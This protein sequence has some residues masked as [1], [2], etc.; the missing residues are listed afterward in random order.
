MDWMK[1]V[2]KDYKKYM[3]GKEKKP[4]VRR[5]L[6]IAALCAVMAGTV[7]LVVLLYPSFRDGTISG[8]EPNDIVESIQEAVTESFQNSRQGE[9][10]FLENLSAQNQ[11]SQSALVLHCYDKDNIAFRTGGGVLAFTDRTILTSYS[12]ATSSRRME[13]YTA[14]EPI[15][16]DRIIAWDKALNIAILGTAEPVQQEPLLIGNSD[17]THKGDE[18][19]VPTAGQ[20]TFLRLSVQE[21]VSDGTFFTLSGTLPRIYGASAVLD[22]Q[23][24]LVALAVEPG[25]T[26]IISTAIPLE[27]IQQQYDERGPGK[28]LEDH[29]MEQHDGVED[30]YLRS[31]PVNLTNLLDDPDLFNSDEN[32]LVRFEADIIPV[33]NHRN[34]GYYYYKTVKPEGRES[35]IE[36]YDQL[37][38]IQCVVTEYPITKNPRGCRAMICG[39]FHYTPAPERSKSLIKTDSILSFIASLTSGLS[40][41][42][43]NYVD[44]LK[45]VIN[46]GEIK[47]VSASLNVKYYEVLDD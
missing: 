43:K 14:E 34:D 26:E 36:F 21:V 1:E 39:Y 41:T 23:G 32:R 18:V 19:I 11:V 2:E 10:S 17:A 27:T 47:N 8:V 5:V 31:I 15:A 42:L 22:R 46:N 13:I 6:V 3:E 28:D 7:A 30:Y 4:K 9:I 24:K 40:D 45:A 37:D 44:N 16:V 20:S 35:G 38:Q 29:F 25:S 12:L 33:E